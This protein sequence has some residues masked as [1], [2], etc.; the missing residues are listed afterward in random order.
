MEGEVTES[1]E[2][3]RQY[4]YRSQELYRRAETLQLASPKH[5]VML[6]A[7]TYEMAA[8]S[9]SILATASRPASN[10]PRQDGIH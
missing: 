8:F 5:A 7:R 3:A 1:M 10:Q 2:R 4:L 6:A 9:A